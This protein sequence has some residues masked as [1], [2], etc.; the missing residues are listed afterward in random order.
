MY[1]TPGGGLQDK[2]QHKGHQGEGCPQRPQ[3]PPESDCPQSQSRQRHSLTS[4]RQ[5]QTTKKGTEEDNN[6]HRSSGNGAK[7][8]EER[9]ANAAESRREGFGSETH[10]SDGDDNEGANSRKE[11]HCCALESK[12]PNDPGG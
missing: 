8:G 1:G 10:G 9:P 2:R 3:E 7:E 6:G 12:A 5:P 4:L 11:N